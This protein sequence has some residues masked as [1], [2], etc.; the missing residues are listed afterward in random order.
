MQLKPEVTAASATGVEAGAAEE[1][2]APKGG[3]QVGEI[4]LKLTSEFPE[5]KRTILPS[6]GQAAASLWVNAHIQA[7]QYDAG[8]ARPSLDVVAV[9]DRSGSMEDEGKLELVKKTLTFVLSQLRPADR[10]ALVTYDTNVRTEFGLTAM[11]E[12]GKKRC[13]DVVRTLQPGSATNLSGGLLQGLRILRTRTEPRDVASVLLLTDG[14]ANYGI[15]SAPELARAMSGSLGHAGAA[16]ATKPTPRARKSRGDQNCR[17][18][19]K[20]S[21]SK[22]VKKSFSKFRG[23]IRRSVKASANDE[24]DNVSLSSCSS[25]CSSSSSSSSD[26]D[27]DWAGTGGSAAAE[28]EGEHGTNK[29]TASAA[30]VYT[31][32]FGS[33]VNS[34][35]LQAIAEAGSGMYY[36]ITGSEDVGG[37]FADCLGGLLSVVAQNMSLRLAVSGA[38]IH[39]VHT[40][41]THTVEASKRACTVQLAD[42]QSEEGKDVLLELSMENAMGASV[43]PE[44]LLAAQLDLFNVITSCES[45]V[46]A[47]P[48]AIMRPH[49]LNAK[50]EADRYIE[51]QRHRIASAQAMER[52]AE[53]AR[54]NQLEQGRKLLRQV[55]FDIGNSKTANDEKAV[56]LLADLDE[57]CSNMQSTASYRSAGAHKLKSK[58]HEHYMQRSSNVY[59]CDSSSYAT[60]SRKAMKS[61]YFM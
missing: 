34:T 16:E 49:E 33:G 14:L 26:S 29:S 13:D 10:L 21:L 28:P 11:D 56:K 20:L 51:V 17:S 1:A 31:F 60:S 57:C 3:S 40:R 27:G 39:K 41:F 43:L 45:T 6:D 19:R 23:P 55:Q 24:N 5:F 35:F 22:K 2:K 8:A 25:S 48:L 37:A 12:D 53:L 58:Q 18:L 46:H 61:A 52:A 7:P 30:S 15:T 9:I 32:G 47:T 59:A 42:L 38:T 44:E 54:S 4:E 36:S 50:A